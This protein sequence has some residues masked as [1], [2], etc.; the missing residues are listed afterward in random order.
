M[1][2]I[3]FT[4]SM[5]MMMECTDKIITQ[6]VYYCGYSCDTMV[7]NIIAQGQDGTVFFVQSTIQAVGP[8]DC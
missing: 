2:I 5:S 3:G 6:N 1:D 7:N 8:T 4:D